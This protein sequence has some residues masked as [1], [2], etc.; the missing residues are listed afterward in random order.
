MKI[1]NFQH[2]YKR[3]PRISIITTQKE[4]IYQSTL[5]ILLAPILFLRHF[6]VFIQLNMHVLLHHPYWIPFFKYVVRE[7]EDESKDYS[8]RA[9]SSFEK[10]SLHNRFG[11]SLQDG[12]RK[13]HR[14][15][16]K[17]RIKHILILLV[18]NRVKLIHW[19]LFLK[20]PQEHI[21]QFLIP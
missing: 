8:S 11:L 12:T 18:Q 6:L 13:Q 4:P 9:K 2:Y 5:Q 20:Y 3:I 7:K 19:C 17:K 14:S 10:R 16:V 15:V 1:K 21:S